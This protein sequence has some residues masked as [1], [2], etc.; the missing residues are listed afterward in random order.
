[1]EIKLK[2]EM[3]SAILLLAFLIYTLAFVVPTPEE[4]SFMGR[5]DVFVFSSEN[6]TETEVEKLR[7]MMKEEVKQMFYS[8]YNNYLRHAFP[9]DELCPMSC[10]GVNT[11]GNLS[12]TLVDAVD[13]L[14]VLGDKIE[15]SR[16]GKRLLFSFFACLIPNVFLLS[17]IK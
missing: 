7:E 6:S 5:K 1:M 13:A 8:G 3:K 12:V 2:K 16:V 15:F 9:K 17:S 10:T 11:F 4:E 14:A